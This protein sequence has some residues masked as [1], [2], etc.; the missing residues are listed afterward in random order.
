MLEGDIRPPKR[1]ESAANTPEGAFLKAFEEHSDALFRHCY[2]RVRDREIA[3]DIVA[4]TF[5]KTWDYL[6]K[7][8]KIDHLRAFLYRVANN[9]IVDGA[10]RKRASS[11]D[12]MMEEDGFEVEDDTTKDP[13]QIG[14]ARVAMK[15]LDSLDEIYRTVITMRLID[16]LTPKEIAAA[17]DVSENVVSVRIYRGIERL[18]S[19]A[20]EKPPRV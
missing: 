1:A 19:I 7:G 10:R 12:A 17:L 6:A 11:L 2:V 18:K 5:T 13:S 16:G 14:D 3:K 20:S 9:L 15:L 4:E 8:K